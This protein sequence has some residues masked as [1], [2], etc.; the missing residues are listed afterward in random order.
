MPQF[1]GRWGV[2]GSQSSDAAIASP[3]LAFKEALEN[4]LT[5]SFS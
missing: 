3:S 4:D 5:L 1:W 2:L